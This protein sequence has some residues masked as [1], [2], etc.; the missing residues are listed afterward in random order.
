MPPEAAGG[1]AGLKPIADFT[2]K[3]SRALSCRVGFGSKASWL[4]AKRTSR[5]WSNPK[6]GSW[7]ILDT[8]YRALSAQVV[9]SFAWRW[10]RRGYG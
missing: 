8:G 1:E 4:A 7:R 2:R 6:V 9:V 3:V 5:F 10:W